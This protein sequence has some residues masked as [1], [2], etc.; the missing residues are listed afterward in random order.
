M[1]CCGPTCPTCPA[2]HAQI[3]PRYSICASCPFEQRTSIH[4]SVHP[5]AIETLNRKPLETPQTGGCGIG[6]GL[7]KR[8]KLRA[9]HYSKVTTEPQCTV[10][11]G[12]SVIF[13]KVLVGISGN[14]RRM[15]LFAYGSH[16]QGS[17]LR[18]RGEYSRLCGARMSTSLGERDN[19]FAGLH[20][21]F[22]RNGH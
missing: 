19:L 10:A 20:G 11:N 18:L 21:C 4:S 3:P 22:R 12:F 14:P 6:R 1:L 17:G 7:D 16:W 8:G 13:A 9:F 2:C 5:S 15:Y